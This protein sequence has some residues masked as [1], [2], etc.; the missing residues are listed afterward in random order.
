MTRTLVMLAALAALAAGCGSARLEAAPAEQTP[1]IALAPIA[2]DALCVTKGAIAD[3]SVTAPTMR[4]FVRGAGGDAAQLVFTFRGETD[5]DRALATSGDRRQLGLKLRA[6]DSCNVIYVMWRLDPK[7]KLD[8]SIKLNAGQRTHDDCGANG[9]TKVRP[10]RALPVP[11]LEAG[12]THTLR[13]EIV[14]DDLAAWIDGTLAWQGHLPDDA[15]TLAG[16]VGIRS[17]NLKLDLVELAAPHGDVPGPACT[18]G[19]HDE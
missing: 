18:R 15:R 19:E 7:P 5:V 17:D 10:Q 6:H 1:S 13:A 8:V 4:A 9:Y 3:R 16:P 14:G 11:A 12:A 2:H